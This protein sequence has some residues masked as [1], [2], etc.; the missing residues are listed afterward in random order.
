MAIEL[1]IFDVTTVAGTAKATPLVTSL[2]FP[3]RLV[4]RIQVVVPPGPNGQLGF[5]FTTGGQQIFPVTPGKFFIASGEVVDLALTDQISSGA[6]QLTTYNTG[7]FDH[8]VQVR[9]HLNVVTATA[10]PAPAE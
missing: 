8:T 6:W 9:F 1:R 3:P 10:Q 7:Q 2:A 4:E 5:Q